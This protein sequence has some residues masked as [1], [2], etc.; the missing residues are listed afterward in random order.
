MVIVGFI[1][2]CGGE[3]GPTL[4]AGD[5]VQALEGVALAVD[6]EALYVLRGSGEVWRAPLAG[7]ELVML[8]A[9]GQLQSKDLAV[10]ATHA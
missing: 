2:G 1:V 3:S 5:V 8:G 7:G 10:D 4:G 6:A 9:S